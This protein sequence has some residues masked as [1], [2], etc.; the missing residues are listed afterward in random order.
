V[1]E[2]NHLGML[3]PRNPSKDPYLV[4]NA[5]PMRGASVLGS[6]L[7]LAAFILIGTVVAVLTR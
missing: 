4:A 6:L 3:P 7:V 5:T 2:P 1:G